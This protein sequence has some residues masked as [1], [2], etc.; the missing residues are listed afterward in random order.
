MCSTAMQQAKS[1]NASNFLYYK[2]FMEPTDHDDLKIESE[3]RKAIDRNELSLHYQPQVDT[4]DGSIIC[5]EALLRWENHE[6]GSVSPARF[7]PLAEKMG[8]IWELGDW[9]LVEACRQMKA[10]EEQGL[11]LPTDRNKYLA[12][13][14]QARFHNTCKRGIE[15]CQPVA[16]D[17]GTRAVR[18]N[19]DG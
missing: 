1:T 9:V 18:G 7:I 16:L 17:A 15:L 6:F 13:A 14:V 10:F 2:E 12:A 5:A 19:I 3:L 8:L 11:E 4:T